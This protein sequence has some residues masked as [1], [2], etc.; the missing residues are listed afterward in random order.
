[1]SDLIKN[2]KIN[3]DIDVENQKFIYKK[4]F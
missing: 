4:N 2:N 3:N 1:M